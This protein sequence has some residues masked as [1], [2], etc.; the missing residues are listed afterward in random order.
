MTT[1][2]ASAAGM[3][4]SAMAATPQ[5]NP[6]PANLLSPAAA[7]MVV[8]PKVDL[9]AMGTSKQDR[10][11]FFSVCSTSEQINLIRM[12]AQAHQ[13]AENHPG[14]LVR[15]VQMAAAAAN[16][17]PGAAAISSA[18]DVA[19]DFKTGQP[20]SQKVLDIGRVALDFTGVGTLVSGAAALVSS[21]VQIKRDEALNHYASLTPTGV[22]KDDQAEIKNYVSE[23]GEPVPTV[24]DLAQ[25][26]DLN[27]GQNL[28]QSPTMR[29]M[30]HLDPKLAKEVVIAYVKTH[31]NSGQGNDAVAAAPAMATPAASP[32]ASAPKR[33][34]QPAPSMQLSAADQA[35][36]ADVQASILAS[37]VAHGAPP[38]RF[39]PLTPLASASSAATS[40]SSVAPAMAP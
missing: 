29:A 40:T 21:G 17:I 34:T 38:Q 10:Q 15:G 32:S 20:V 18:S 4:T 36:P 1:L 19:T 27:P 6:V 16:F 25:A 24:R 39:T 30:F 37:R 12:D 5:S 22:Q 28:S 31:A 7:S 33:F 26:I 9:P 14:S 8:V 11:S 2:A 3:A 13:Q 35:L 23:F